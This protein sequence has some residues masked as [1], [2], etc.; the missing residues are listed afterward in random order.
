MDP[1]TL[2]IIG[3]VTALAGSIMKGIAGLV[4]KVAMLELLWYLIGVIPILLFQACITMFVTLMDSS[5]LVNFNFFPAASSIASTPIIGNIVSFLTEL[6]GKYQNWANM[7]SG[8]VTQEIIEHMAPLTATLDAI[9]G[10]LFAASMLL[11]VYKMIFA[12]LTGDKAMSPAKI[13]YLEIIYG[14]LFQAFPAD[15]KFPWKQCVQHAA[16]SGKY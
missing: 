12:P 4:S 1:V 16:K 8:N 11:A 6:V 14:R 13:I 3:A 7:N 15:N 10:G 9:A 5:F 2:A